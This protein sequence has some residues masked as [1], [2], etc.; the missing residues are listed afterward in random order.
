LPDEVNSVII[1]SAVNDQWAGKENV[2]MNELVRNVYEQ[3]YKPSILF[4]NMYSPH[5]EWVNGAPSIDTLAQ[6]YD[7]PVAQILGTNLTT[8]PLLT[9]PSTKSSQCHILSET[10]A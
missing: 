9:L 5:L 7:I 8:G 1:E 4:F 3:A 10:R 6:Y 2:N